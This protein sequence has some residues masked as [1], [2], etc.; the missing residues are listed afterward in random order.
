MVINQCTGRA[1]GNPR[2]SLVSSARC[3]WKPPSA[4]NSAPSVTLCPEGKQT[5]I[6]THIPL[7]C[8][9]H[10]CRNVH[11]SLTWQ[12]CTDAHIIANARRTATKTTQFSHSVMRSLLFQLCVR[13][14]RALPLKRPRR[15]PQDGLF[16]SPRWELV[17]SR[18]FHLLIAPANRKCNI[19]GV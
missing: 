1:S 8:L 19:Y 15:W 5:H 7:C 13:G 11:L 16:C 9:Q 4:S 6:W 18:W 10:K 17:Y 14:D 12:D 2:R 3:T